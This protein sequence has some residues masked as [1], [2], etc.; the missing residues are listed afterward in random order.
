MTRRTPYNPQGMQQQTPDVFGNTN[1]VIRNSKQ[2]NVLWGISCGIIFLWLVL[3]SILFPLL[4]TNFHH[5]VQ[6]TE[7][8]FAED[9]VILWNKLIDYNETA[10]E[11]EDDISETRESID[12]L[13]AEG[14]FPELTQN[15]ILRGCWDASTNTP[16][17][18]NTNGEFGDLYVVCV[19]GNATTLNGISSW[20]IDD[21]IKRVEDYTPSS[22]DAWVTLAKNGVTL[23]DSPSGTGESLV[24][25][26]AGDPLELV[27]LQ[28]LGNLTLVDQGDYIDLL[29][30][31]ATPGSQVIP[32]WTLGLVDTVPDDNNSTLVNIMRQMWT[33]VGN[34]LHVTLTLMV[35]VSPFGVVGEHSIPVDGFFTLIVPILPDFP[36]NPWCGVHQIFEMEDMGEISVKSS[37][38][39]FNISASPETLALKWRVDYVAPSLSGVFDLKFYCVWNDHAPPSGVP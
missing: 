6:N 36:H 31:V 24:V 11:F 38:S 34:D 13:C 4:Y 18:N 15:M 17:L 35:P 28:A 22:S 26:G 5:K 23:S 14:V 37:G 3:A 8:Q 39:L 32:Y 25:V 29:L 21:L 9:K 16:E 33:H 7:E 27:Q 10:I 20:V 1:T 2:V 12:G 30:D 19:P